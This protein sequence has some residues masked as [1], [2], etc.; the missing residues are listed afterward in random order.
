MPQRRTISG[1]RTK[2][3][4]KQI[5]SHQESGFHEKTFQTKSGHARMNPY[6][7]QY[8][9][10]WT[11]YSAVGKRW[12]A[13]VLPKPESKTPLCPRQGRSTN[14][15]RKSGIHWMRVRTIVWRRT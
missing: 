12:S 4:T 7:R 11:A 9:R 5:A 1:I 14:G 6:A 2:V 13:T 8:S 3:W 10:P 15:R